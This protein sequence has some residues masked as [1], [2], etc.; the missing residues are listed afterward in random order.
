[1]YNA[2]TDLPTPKIIKG[3]NV[4]SKGCIRTGAHHS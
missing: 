1:M 4:K 3:K 2:L